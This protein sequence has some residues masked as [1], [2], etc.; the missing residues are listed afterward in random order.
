MTAN[1][2][3]VCP[4]VILTCSVVGIPSSTLRWFFNNNSVL[5][6]YPFDQT[7][8]YPLTVEPNDALLGIVEIM[9][10]EAS[11]NADNVDL[12]N[13]ISTLKVNAAALQAVGVSTIMCGSFGTRSVITFHEGHFASSTGCLSKHSEAQLT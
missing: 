4:E 6:T 12:T 5:A 8:E 3:S 1:L 10:L 2:S 9:I 13:F 11:L 7:D